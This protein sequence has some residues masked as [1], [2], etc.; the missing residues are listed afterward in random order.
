MAPDELFG[1]GEQDDG[2]P[3]PDDEPIEGAPDVRLEDLPSDLT[4][5]SPPEGEVIEGLPGDGENGIG[6]EVI[7]GFPDNSN[8]FPE[9]PPGNS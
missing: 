2:F 8:G 1:N 3:P 9:L 4:D 5:D 6:G 7:E